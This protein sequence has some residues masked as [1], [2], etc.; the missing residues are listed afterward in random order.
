MFAYELWSLIF[1]VFGVA[2]VMPCSVMELLACWEGSFGKGRIWK[3]VFL[4]IMWCKGREMAIA[5]MVTNK[6][7]LSYLSK[8]I[9]LS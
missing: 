8:K 6:I 2:L 9:D 4:C 3:T 7:D 5:L 1:C